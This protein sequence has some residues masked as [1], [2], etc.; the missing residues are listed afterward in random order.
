MR[1]FGSF[2]LNNR[3]WL[4]AAILALS[5]ALAFFVPELKIEEDETTWF[6][7]DD[8]VLTE[9]QKMEQTFITNDIVLI[10]YKTPGA[11]QKTELAYCAALS[12]KLKNIPSVN[13]V[14][15][16]STVDD[17]IGTAEG[18]EIRP[19]VENPDASSAENSGLKQ[20]IDRNPFFKKILVADDYR[21]LG[22]VV[23][24]KW[25]E[26]TQKKTSDLSRETIDALKKFLR[27][28]SEATGRQFFVGGNAMNNTEVSAMVERDMFR[29]F[30]LSLLLAAVVLLIIF[31]DLTSLI[32]PIVSVVLALLW[33]LGLKGMSGVPITPVSTTLFALI[34]VIGI[35]NS[36]HLISY[37]NS[38]KHAHPT[39]R[40]ALLETIERA[41][42]ACLFN[43]ITTVFGFGSLCISP[44]PAIRNMGIFAS[45]GIMLSFLFSFI[46]VSSGILLFKPGGPAR[47]KQVDEK[48]GGL[49][50]MISS[51][52]LHYPRTI[53][54]IC[55]A[56]TLLMVFGIPNI[57]VESSMLEYLKKHCQLRKD[58][59]FIDSTLAGISSVEVMLT[60]KEDSFKDPHILNNLE[61]LQLAV[62]KHP[63]VSMSHSIADY[64]KLINRA[65]HEDEQQYYVI[66]E[67]REA[68]AQSL[69]LYEMSGG[70]EL[71]EYVTTTC[72]IARI[73]INTRQMNQKQR[74]ALLDR[75]NRFCIDNF[76]TLEYTVTG[77]DNLVYKTT[78]RIVS[79]LIQS[80]ALALLVILL[81]MCLLFGLRA[82]LV[83]IVPNCLPIFFLLGL[84]GYGG[85]KL[86]VATAIIASIAIGIVVDDTIHY[87]FHFKHE[88]SITGD[89]TLAM[90]NAHRKVGSAMIFT[91]LILALGFLIFVLSETRI[92]SNYGLLSC[93]TVIVA[94]FGD[95]FL[96]PV[97][98]VKLPVFKQNYSK[99]E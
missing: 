23:R 33:T 65:L 88:L 19:L 80:L 94:L 79:T 34:N 96:G 13:E 83:S 28:E 57:E 85:F 3:Y 76:P 56:A 15:S 69:L 5:A 2:I 17:I 75:I 41:G 14:I 51:V 50:N 24:L 93:T 1:R 47:V 10:A 44:L 22:I 82:G 49:L 97:L 77:F 54:I 59:E 16:L 32:F 52:N 27:Q 91:S 21:T 4:I 38:V 61:R 95:L 39:V 58:A 40:D 7:N 60:G 42:K 6:Y 74:N 43:A 67:T 87:F 31:R 12:E 72:D 86:D 73:S 26:S 92:L 78:Q 45:V 53:I 9:Y 81:L 70:T 25:E 62:Q 48:R 66:P 30:P 99:T 84:M 18:L 46:I 68:V 71:E 36:V 90:I 8:P 20:R 63:K 29:F 89:R 64:V 35:A 11:L 55:S 37:Y 98:L